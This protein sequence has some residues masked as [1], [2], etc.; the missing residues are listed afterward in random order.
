MCN[1]NPG[2]LLKAERLLTEYA[3]TSSVGVGRS[4]MRSG[5]FGMGTRDGIFPTQTFHSS[6]LFM[7]VRVKFLFSLTVVS[8]DIRPGFLR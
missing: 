4:Q 7:F 6:F 3:E 1:L 2:L 5:G 8:S